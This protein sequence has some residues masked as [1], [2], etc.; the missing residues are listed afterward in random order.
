LLQ[1]AQRSIGI[2]YSPYTIKRFT[3]ISNHKKQHTILLKKDKAAKKSD[4]YNAF[5]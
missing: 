4:A 3:T 5:P 1:D 2:Y